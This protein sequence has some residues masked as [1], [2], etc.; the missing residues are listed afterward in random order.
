MLQYGSTVSVRLPSSCTEKINYTKL[1]ADV[2]YPESFVRELLEAHASK[3]PRQRPAT[4]Q[5]AAKSST[6]QFQIG[7][8]REL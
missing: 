4:R 2:Q 8:R 7:K 6:I 5:A 1:A 3:E